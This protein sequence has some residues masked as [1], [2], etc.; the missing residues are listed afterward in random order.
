[1]LVFADLGFVRGP[2]PTLFIHPK[3]TGDL[4]TELDCLERRELTDAGVRVI[5]ATEVGILERLPFVSQA[6]FGEM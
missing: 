6:E 4:P 2:D 3:F 1:V 5:P